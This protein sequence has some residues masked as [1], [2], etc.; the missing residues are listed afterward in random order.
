MP[1]QAAFTNPASP[2][3]SVKRLEKLPAPAKLNLFLHVTG[4]R[5]D[6]M[7]LLESLF[8]LVDLADELTIERL[9]DDSIVRTGDVVGDVEK[10]LCVRAAKA[11][12]EYAQ[13]N[14]GAAIDVKKKIPSGAGMG[15][16]SSD[17]ATT[18][19]A[20]NR[21]W[22]LNLSKD[23]LMQIASRLGADVPFFIFGQN[24]FA[25][26]IG[27]KLTP[28][29]VPPSSWFVVMPAAPTPTAAVFCDEFLTRDTK[30]LKIALFSEQLLTC[31][32][33]LL[34]RNDL[35]AVARR[36]NPDVDRALQHLSALGCE[37][38]MTGSGSAVFAHMPSFESAQA[39]LAK[40]PAGMTGYAVRTL[41]EHP[42][43][44]L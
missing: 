25:S 4:R 21:L 39:M 2:Q 13:I 36:I 41:S 29:A 14:L 10:D 35:E 38:R 42:L 5:A 8:I 28:V 34:G 27:E 43:K 17:C 30:S 37:A 7:H 11:L 18:L 24:A 33:H 3:Q 15:G 19:L 22:E 16:G 20:L 44:D 23:E 32:P 6:G 31:W 9:E 12:R 26:G 40:T 1:T